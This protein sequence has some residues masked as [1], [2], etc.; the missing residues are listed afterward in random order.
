[1]PPSS[2]PEPAEEIA[3]TIRIGIRRT[4]RPADREQCWDP[5]PSRS[6][7]QMVEFFDSFLP[8]CQPNYK[9]LDNQ[10]ELTK[11]SGETGP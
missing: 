3:T 11:T 8:S 4:P 6:S 5:I 10:K 1:M 9:V 2:S 7:E